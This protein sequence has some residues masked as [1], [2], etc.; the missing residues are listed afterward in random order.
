MQTFSEIKMID[1]SRS[2]A[3]RREAR[4][5]CGPYTWQP[6]RAGSGRGFYMGSDGASCDPRGSTFRLR[7]EEVPA[8]RRGVCGYFA[9]PDADSFKPIIARLPHGRGYLAGW[10]LGAGMCAELE[11]ELHADEREAR[12][13]AHD[14]AER[15][16]D[17]EAEYLATID[18]Q[19]DEDEDEGEGE[20]EDTW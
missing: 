16:A 6:S 9:D 13:A 1:Y 7:L 10:T 5:F 2:L 19:D 18:D 17:R 20:G 3:E 11:P 12:H 4:R 14:A 15:A 8:N